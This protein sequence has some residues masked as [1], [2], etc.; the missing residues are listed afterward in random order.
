MGLLS[1]HV[2]RHRL[3]SLQRMHE[4]NDSRLGHS[5]HLA[6]RLAYYQLPPGV[7]PESHPE[8]PPNA[9]ASVVTFALLFVTFTPSCLARASI[10]TR[11][12]DETACDILE[13]ESVTVLPTIIDGPHSAAK[14]RLCIKS[15][16]ISRVLCTRNALWP[17][18][19]MWR[20]FLL[21]PYPIYGHQRQ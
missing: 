14:V 6:I 20:V 9:H 10:S 21:E 2:P 13:S 4:R 18:G 1:L 7:L 16:S 17:E 15:M 3:T 11:F 8:L 5:L 12:L 19:I